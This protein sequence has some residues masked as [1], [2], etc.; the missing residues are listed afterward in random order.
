M[1]LTLRGARSFLPAL[2]LSGLVACA[3]PPPPAPPPPPPTALQVD[4]VAMPNVNPD[5]FGRPSP[6]VF[7]FYELKSLAAFTNADFFALVDKDKDVLAAELVAREEFQLTPGDKRHFERKVQADT[8]YIGVVA[9]FRDLE[10][11]QWRASMAVTP[12]KTSV[13]DVQLDASKVTIT[14]R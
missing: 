2:L 5:A 1:E 12:Q 9:A 4:I 10:K 11:A 8:R 6:V 7:R 3:S 14:S 13:V